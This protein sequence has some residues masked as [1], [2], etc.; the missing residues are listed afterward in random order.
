MIAEPEFR[1]CDFFSGKKIGNEFFRIGIL[2]GFKPVDDVSF[3]LQFA[4]KYILTFC[5]LADFIEQLV[6]HLV[7]RAFTLQEKGNFPVFQTECFKSFKGDS[8]F[9]MQFAYF[10]DHAA[11]KTGIQTQFD[12]FPHGFTGV[13]NSENKRRNLKRRRE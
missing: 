7:K 11:L 10:I 13:E 9:I 8:S 3:T 12:S 5:E 6:T 1:F 2:S 4:E